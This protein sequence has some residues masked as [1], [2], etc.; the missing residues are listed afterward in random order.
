M[1]ERM[2]KIS[3]L[4]D[5]TPNEHSSSLITDQWVEISTGTSHELQRLVGSIMKEYLTD[6]FKAGNRRFVLW[7]RFEYQHW[8]G[9]STISCISLLF[10]NNH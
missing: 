5:L 8:E 6:G 9:D 4:W 7:L 10:A 3:L 2:P 1:P